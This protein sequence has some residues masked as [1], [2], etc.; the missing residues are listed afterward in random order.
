[1]LAGTGHLSK[2]G[3]EI[4]T[5]SH[6]W[7]KF[8]VIKTA[9]KEEDGEKIFTCEVCRQTKTEPYSYAGDTEIPERAFADKDNLKDVTI[10]ASVTKIG[11]EAFAGCPNLKEIYFEGDKPEL[12]KDV[13]K[14]IDPDAVIYYPE[15]NQTW[16][17]QALQD[18]GIA[19]RTA[20]WNPQEGKNII[21]DLADLAV[22]TEYKSVTYDGTPKRPAVTVK[23]GQM[24]LKAGTDY[25]V[26]YGENVNAGTGTVK[27]TGL[28]N[29]KG[30]AEATFLIARAK[31][32]ITLTETALTKK[33]TDPAFTL[34]IR[35]V[36][37]DG[38][39]TYASS[40]PAVAS[41][42]PQSGRVKILKAGTTNLMAMAGG[43]NYT[44]EAA[45][46]TLTVNDPAPAGT[47]SKKD[48]A[49]KK[50]NVISASDLTV[51]GT[52]K[53]Q[54]VSVKASAQ[55][56]AKLSFISDVNAVKI[57]E[58]G[59]LYVPAAFAGRVKVTVTSAETTQ[60][61]KASKTIS[62]IVLPKSMKLSKA[63]PSGSRKAKVTW[64][65]NDTAQGYEL[66]YATNK[67]FTKKMKTVSIKKQATV[68]KTVKKL[69][70]G[71][72]YYFRIRAY[73][74]IDGTKY[75][76]DWSKAKKVKIKK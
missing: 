72:K 39:V 73:V 23:D 35:E 67:T 64:E 57:S 75:Y 41:I 26:S 14:D 21:R 55:G 52:G 59:T 47:G 66:Q 17:Q 40:N 12:G 13:F 24:T 74:K 58:S 2:N 9:T 15:G 38:T 8:E 76:S 29:Y 27:V 3:D 69:K 68:K 51:K 6:T 42:D 19:L 25:T 50:N 65:K 62:V 43:I 32:M 4:E 70:G 22:T 45:A 1:M 61:K 16:T 36:L 49:E 30:T 53:A 7:G 31:G 71:K 34:E 56:N 54:A 63:K 60:Y 46:F 48:A 37:T 18:A 11:D 33:V 10:G 20:S 5:I 28:D 44:T